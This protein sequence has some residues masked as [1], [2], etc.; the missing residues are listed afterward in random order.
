M[1]VASLCGFGGS[2]GLVTRNFGRPITVKSSE[3]GRT[4]VEIARFTTQFM[5]PIAMVSCET[6]D[7]GKLGR[8]S[9]APYQR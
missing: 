9:I 5:Q 7:E 2:R 1:R 4:T 3:H 8:S 6:D